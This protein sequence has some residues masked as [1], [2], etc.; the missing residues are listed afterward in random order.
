MGV[1][2]DHLEINAPRSY[3]RESTAGGLG[4]GLGAALGA[5]LV[6]PER[7]VIAVVGD[8]SYMFGNPTPAHFMARAQTLGTLTVINNNQRWQA[9]HN[10]T[11]GMYPDGVAS[12]APEMPLTALVPSPEFDKVVFSGELNVVHGPVKTQFG[13]HLLEITS[14][15]E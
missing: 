7:E 10:A 5:K 15:T 3:M 13:Y 9:V 6:A 2:A 11:V 1:P 14:R 12:N 4:F 8:G